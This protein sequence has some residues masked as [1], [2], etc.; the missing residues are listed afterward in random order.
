MCNEH[1]IRKTLDQ[2]KGDFGDFDIPFWAD[3]GTNMQP[4]DSIRITDRS[5]VVRPYEGGGRLQEMRWSWPGPGGK[6]V[7]NFRAEGR[8]FPLNT[9]CLVLT[10]GFFEF[11]DPEPGAKRKT[12]WLFTLGED[13]LFAIAGVMRRWEDSAAFSMLTTEPGPDVAPYH[14]RSVA[15]L[16]PDRWKAWLAGEP[17]GRLLEPPPAG[18]L[19][20]SR[21][22]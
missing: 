8:S 20:V 5:P 17:E 2:L 11:T 10:D 1:R 18:T 21:V 16:P 7:Y 12:K 9:R 15:V 13:R 4:R 22:G 6:P 3:G 19:S 14:H